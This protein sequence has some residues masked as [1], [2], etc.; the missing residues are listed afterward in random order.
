MENAEGDNSSQAIK[1]RLPREIKMKLAKV[2]R[3]AVLSVADLITSLAAVIITAK[4]S[5][6]ST[7]TFFVLFFSDSSLAMVK[8]QRS[9]LTDL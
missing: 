5:Q 3:L 9:Y 1:R 4:Y 2:A 8:Y 6:V 7:L